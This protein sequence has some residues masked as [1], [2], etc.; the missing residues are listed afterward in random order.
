MF[1]LMLKCADHLEK[2]LE[3]LINQQ[4]TVEC[5][6]LTTK[7]TID[8][9]GTC[10]FGIEMNALNE[11]SKFYK[12]GKEVFNPSRKN[13]IRMRIIRYMPQLYNI[14]SYILPQRE[15]TKFFFR[16]IL[17]TLDYREKN[18]IVRHDFIDI[19]RELKKHPEKLSDIGKL[20]FLLYCLLYFFFNYTSLLM[21]YNSRHYNRIKCCFNVIDFYHLFHSLHMYKSC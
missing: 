8:V 4:K 12:M 21:R 3:K 1:S 19:L 7:Y 15:V 5:C 13:R 9:I 14:V 11:N 6:E 10:I 2:Y 17:E 16:I 18:N 20:L